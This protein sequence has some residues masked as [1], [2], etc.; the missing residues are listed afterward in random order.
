MED[1]KP[2]WLSKTIWTNLIALIGS[3]V[4]AVGFDP[5]RWAEIATVALAVINLG[6][7]LVTNEEITLSPPGN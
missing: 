5:G 7:R 2:W 6:L 4:I 1:P 3:F